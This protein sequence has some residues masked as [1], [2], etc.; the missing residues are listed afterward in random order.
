MT[1][2]PLLIILAVVCVIVAT[3]VWYIDP[4]Y[5]RW[6]KDAALL[7]QFQRHKPAFEWLRETALQK[8][9]K[10]WRFS[11]S[12]LDQGQGAPFAGDLPHPDLVVVDNHDGRGIVRFIYA[13]GGSILSIGPQW[14]KGIAYLPS[15]PE[16]E[17]SQVTHLDDPEALPWGGSYVSKID[18]NWYIYVQKTE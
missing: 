9:D 5:W 8:S 10:A 14:T 6:P 15:E 18:Q 3:V 13:E 2:K 16:R 1:H 12:D 7:S 4:L 17:G 11:P